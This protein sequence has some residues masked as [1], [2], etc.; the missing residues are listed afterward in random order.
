MAGKSQLGVKLPL[1]Q[2]RRRVRLLESHYSPATT[3]AK[4]GEGIPEMGAGCISRGTSKL[5]VDLTVHGHATYN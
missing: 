5:A 3:L 4:P 1:L 2:K